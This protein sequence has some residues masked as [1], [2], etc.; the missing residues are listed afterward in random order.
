MSPDCHGSPISNDRLTE[1]PKN[2]VG[3][4]RSRVENAGLFGGEQGVCLELGVAMVFLSAGF[5]VRFD[6]QWG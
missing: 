6:A 2:D 3:L 1:G 5:P 4:P